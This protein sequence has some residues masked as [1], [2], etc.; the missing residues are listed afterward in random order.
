MQINGNNDIKDDDYTKY[1]EINDEIGRGQFCKVFKGV[2][3]K[4]KEMRA[5]KIIEIYNNKENNFIKYIINELNNM[6][7]CSKENDNSVKYYEHFHYK[8]KFAIVMELCDNSLQKILDAREEGFTCEQIFNI[9]SQLNKT[10]KI[11]YENKIIHRDI[12]L[13]NILVKYK[14]YNNNDSNINFIVK[15]TDYGISKQFKNTINT[16]YM[17]TYETMAP[18]ILEGEENYDNKCDL[19]SIGIIIYQLFFKEYPYKGTPVA[20]YNKIKN[21]GKKVL[22]KTKNEKLD[23]LIESLLIREPEKRID[24]EEFFNHPFFK[25][26][27]TNN[28]SIYNNNNNN[29][30]KNEYNNSNYNTNNTIQTKNK[31]SFY[32]LQKKKFIN[33]KNFSSNNSSLKTYESQSF[34][35]IQPENFNKNNKDI[36]PNSPNSMRANISKYLESKEKDD[37]DKLNLENDINKCILSLNQ[38]EINYSINIEDLLILEE[39]LK[40]IIL[41]INNVESIYSQCLDLWIYF[42]NFS[43]YKKLEKSFKTES[44]KNIFKI[45][46]NHILLSVIICYDYSYEMEVLNNG[47]S[48]LVT[49]LMKNHQNLMI[50]YDYILSKISAGSKSN[51]FVHKLIQ[52]V[53]GYFNFLKEECIPINGKFNEIIK[54]NIGI[55]TENLRV[56]LKNYKTKRNKYLISIFKKIDGIPYEE[57]DIL[58]KKNILRINKFKG[59]PFAS[60]F[61]EDNKYFQTVPSPYIKIKNVKPF[62]LI[63]DSDETLIHFEKNI[64]NDYLGIL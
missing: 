36:S 9:M 10:F 46:I 55:I 18:E 33:Y 52:I 13:D 6:K 48:F 28:S 25:E 31:I 57:I 61:L 34:S 49:I 15:L 59:S 40:E 54:Y 29:L 32:G 19:W 8:D 23:N 24:Y 7:L 30:N 62:S 50:N 5:I 35:K 21:L 17:G 39:K 53:T 14:D 43:I 2:N 27:Y 37:E 60:I 16:S 45:S 47:I 22:K 42:S 64:E 1:Y 4:S 38:Q 41:P 3:K 11:M 44:D 26:K 58:F 12:K 63:L 56:L 20:I 51:I